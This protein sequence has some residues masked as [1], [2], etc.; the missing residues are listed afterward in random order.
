MAQRQE[1]NQPKRKHAANGSV[2]T[3]TANV[4]ACVCACMS[5]PV[6]V[7]VCVCV[8]VCV[9]VHECA[10]KCVCVCLAISPRVSETRPARAPLHFCTLILV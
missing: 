3:P 10:R 6:C 2:L 1:A 5:V 8:C 7:R 9:C 4:C